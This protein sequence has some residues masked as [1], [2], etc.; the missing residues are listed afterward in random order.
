MDVTVQQQCHEV[1]LI[2]PG[3]RWLCT[4]H[5]VQRRDHDKPEANCLSEGIRRGG[6]GPGIFAIC[7]VKARVGSRRILFD[8]GLLVRPARAAVAC[9]TAC[10]PAKSPPQAVLESLRGSPPSVRSLPGPHARCRG[11]RRAWAWNVQRNACG[12][13][14]RVRAEW[15]DLLSL[16]ERSCRRACVYTGPNAYAIIS[17]WR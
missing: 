12:V 11:G 9:R 16:R 15:T 2:M 10:L 14:V 5:T 4:R 17:L 8:S 3:S 7:H 1:Q 6:W 13:R